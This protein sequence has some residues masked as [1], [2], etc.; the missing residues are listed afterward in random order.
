MFMV[1]CASSTL[2]I[3]LVEF[4]VQIYGTYFYDYS[5]IHFVFV[6]DNIQRLDSEMFR[7]IFVFQVKYSLLNKDIN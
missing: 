1:V 5:D 2:F 7:S 6:G 3:S 4:G